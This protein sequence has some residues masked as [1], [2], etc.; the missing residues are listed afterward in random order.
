MCT[1]RDLTEERC[2]LTCKELEDFLRLKISRE[3]SVE[4][5]V[6]R[7]HEKG[8]EEGEKKARGKLC[9]VLSS[10]QSWSSLAGKGERQ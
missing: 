7:D 1:A 9:T 4:E 6:Q 10:H 2:W 8:E 3:E 5:R